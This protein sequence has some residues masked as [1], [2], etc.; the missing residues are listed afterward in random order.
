MNIELRHYI[1]GQ[2]GE[3]DDERLDVV[4]PHSGDVVAI[5]P[6]GSRTV[7][8]IAVRGAVEAHSLWAQLP[9]EA[10]IEIV[11][12]WA[13][14]IERHLDELAQ[15]QCLE[16]GQ[17]LELGR[18]IMS[19]GL[20]ELRA[21][22]EEARAYEFRRDLVVEG[23]GTTRIIRHSLGAVA[24]ITPW[25]FPITTILAAIGPLLLAG[26]TVLVKP[27]ELSPI[28][29]VRLFELLDIPDGVMSLVLGD[30]RAGQ[31]LVEHPDVRFVHFTGSVETGR[32]VASASAALLRRA[33]LELGGKD[34]VVIDAGVD[35]VV[36]AQAVAFGSFMN[37]GQICTSMERIY[38]H[39][40]VAEEFVSA[41]VDMALGY[42][43]ADLSGNGAMNELG[44]MVTERQRQIVQTHVDDAVA[45]GATVRVGGQIPDG[46]GYFY[47]ATVLV[48]VDDDMTVMTEET[49][50]PIAPVCVVPTFEEGVRRASAGR[51]ALAATVYTQ[52]PS[53]AQTAESIPAGLVWINQWQG[54]GP[55]RIY[56]PA[57]D[58]G[59]GATG[60]TAAF[61]AATRPAS[62]F[63]ASPE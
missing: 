54:G 30:G 27:S 28:S 13:D 62:V 53:H 25:N 63:I 3:W 23:S 31:P 26:N 16:M 51:F 8:D 4:N 45:R 59:F 9:L 44:P 10:R 47:P 60:S 21:S 42:A 7:V 56:E 17:P 22:V 48:D 52:D 34:P 5:C 58:S 41:L 29:A 39:Q 55:G 46:P 36:T 15:V 14:T 49:F 43:R 50:G 19:S 40:D 6:S 33:A 11:N 18:M 35:P 38:V 61:D 12:A 1:G 2:W 32:R 20:A 37:S 24:V 57:R